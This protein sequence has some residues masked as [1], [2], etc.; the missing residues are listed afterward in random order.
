MTD[1]EAPFHLQISKVLAYNIF[2]LLSMAVRYLFIDNTKSQNHLLRINNDISNPD[3]NIISFH[4]GEHV[5]VV[6]E[7]GEGELGRELFSICFTDSDII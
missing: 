4:R 6:L 3:Y 5:V 1:N 7:V 2:P